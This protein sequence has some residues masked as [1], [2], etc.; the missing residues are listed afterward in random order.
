M[1]GATDSSS[2]DRTSNE[3]VTA[4]VR[5]V[6][7][8]RELARVSGREAVAGPFQESLE[9]AVLANGV[10]FR[11]GRVLRALRGGRLEKR[12]PFDAIESV[13]SGPGGGVILSPKAGSGAGP[14]RTLHGVA[15]TTMLAI[16]W[17]LQGQP[18]SRI[19]GAEAFVDSRFRLRR[20]GV[21]FGGPAGIVFVPSGW[22][23]AVD[24]SV[25]TVSAADIYGFDS[26]PDGVKV[27]TGSDVDLTLQ[28]RLSSM[29]GIAGW[30]AR[31]SPRPKGDGEV[32]EAKVV[33][34]A[35]NQT[36]R[37]AELTIEDS[38]LV[39]R[40][41]R[42]ELSLRAPLGR[43]ELTRLELDTPN[44][45]VQ[46]RV[47]GIP[48]VMR[49]L[50]RT[51][52]LASLYTILKENRGELGLHMVD[53]DSFKRV[54]GEHAWV[55][56]FHRAGVEVVMR[57]IRADV[58]DDGIHLEGMLGGDDRFVIATGARV[59][60]SIPSGRAVLEFAASLVEAQ[61]HA[62]DSRR[63]SLRLI[64]GLDEITTTEGRRVFHRIE[65][66]TEDIFVKCFPVGGRAP[67]GQKGVWPG[68]RP[69]PSVE[70]RLVDISA[71]GVCL[72]MPS[73]PEIGTRMRVRLPTREAV[74]D[75]EVEVV[76]VQAERKESSSYRVGVR[77]VGITEKVRAVLQREVLRYERQ[78]RA[79]E[80]S[81]DE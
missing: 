60:V 40:D 5:P 70:Y 11:R 30:F 37:R 7:G 48:H 81:D 45:R 57:N 1:S 38:D 15:A 68:A 78:L 20:S 25:V 75:L 41:E 13:V 19:V 6:E 18:N 4:E 71:G 2:N 74:G 55:R 16:W 52:L 61:T 80:S 23:S 67:G 47:E 54:A 56:I 8:Q 27:L 66:P 3:T 17:V 50:G 21:A 49:P 69:P 42:G 39:L 29:E 51:E 58:R 73:E 53:P 43:V 31:I 36:I 33:W 62:D 14:A 9:L 24:D 63:L 12:I 76:H 59:R 28:G 64:P 26:T 32:G 46:V 77:V 35:D 65:A 34:A 72:R 22:L 79:A 10:I 44:P